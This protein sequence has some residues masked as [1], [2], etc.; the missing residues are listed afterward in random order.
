MGL[1]RTVSEIN[2]NF[3]QKSQVFHAQC[4]CP[5]EFCNA[6]RAQ[7]L[8]TSSDGPTKRQK[9]FTIRTT[10]IVS[11]RQPHWINRRTEMV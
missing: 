6:G 3:D 7:E 2:G 5:L 10:T 11:I 8:N 1:S 4:I 9:S